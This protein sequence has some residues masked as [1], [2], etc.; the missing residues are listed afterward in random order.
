MVRRVITVRVGWLVLV[1]VL[2]LVA[3]LV[4]LVRRPVATGIDP[5]RVRAVCDQYAGLDLSGLAP[6]CVDAG[7]QARRI[8]VQPPAWPRITRTIDG[9]PTV[10]M[11][12]DLDR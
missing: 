7:Y 6:L 9:V 8:Y 4:L 1:G 2:V 11:P 12:E 3:L 5:A 10:P